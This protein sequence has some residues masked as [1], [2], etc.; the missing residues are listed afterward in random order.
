MSTTERVISAGSPNQ[1][2]WVTLISGPGEQHE[3]QKPDSSAKSLVTFIHTSDWHICDAE[4]PARQ[5]YL[6]RWFDPDSKF[7]ADIGFIGTYRPQEAFT[8]QVAATWIETLNEIYVGPVLG[9]PIDAVVITGDVSDNAQHNEI[10]WYLTLLDGGH[11]D[12]SGGREVSHWVGSTESVTWDARYWHPEGSGEDGEV[13]LPTSTYG[14]PTIP[15]LLR[16]ARNEIISKGLRH[17]WF[18][19]HG[20]HD[21]LL[22][23]TVSPDETLEALAVGDQRVIG[24]PTGVS[25]LTVS[26]AIPGVGK[27]RYIHDHTYPIEEVPSDDSRKFLKPG[28]FAKL[29]LSSTSLPSGHGFTEQNTSD[30]SAYFSKRIGDVLLISIDTVNLNGGWQGSIDRKQFD[31]LKSQLEVNKDEYVILAS[32]H[33]VHCL[34]NGFKSNEEPERVLAQEFLDLVF[35]YPNVMA[36]L[37]GHEHK[38]AVYTHAR[39]DRL[40]IEINS[41]SLI[42][43]PQQGRIVEIAREE[44]GSIVI[45]STV[46]DHDGEIYPDYQRLS[47]DDIAGIS[48]LLAV[49]DYQRREP[50]TSVHR[51]SGQKT[52]RNFFLRIPDPFSRAQTTKL[53]P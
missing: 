44:S 1:S 14:F 33:P 22:Q 46:I 28:D 4:S 43:W 39:E 29:H 23:G 37:T 38:H 19:I 51:L 9:R 5:E 2:G 30:N 21:A 41:P 49:N 11:L 32:H 42:D 31:W 7:R 48:R 10:D 20:N 16:A 47:Q 45:V 36:M 15:G 17:N 3:G 50:A 8:L 53:T 6:D 24:M 25:P 40:F 12:P 35:E 34:I 13:D 52:E 27:A 18:S 26:E